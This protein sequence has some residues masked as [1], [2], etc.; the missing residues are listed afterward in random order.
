[1]LIKRAIV[2]DKLT[3]VTDGAFDV[4]TGSAVVRSRC[5]NDK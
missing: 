3:V 5:R 2:N 1:M 4:V